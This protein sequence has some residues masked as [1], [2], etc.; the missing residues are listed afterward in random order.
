M[1]NRKARDPSCDYSVERGH[2]GMKRNRG[3]HGPVRDTDPVGSILPGVK[4]LQK[5]GEENVRAAGKMVA[6]P[7]PRKRQPTEG[8]NGVG[9]TKA[10]LKKAKAAR[11]AEVGKV[12]AK[13]ASDMAGQMAAD[14]ERFSQ[15][16]DRAVQE[17]SAMMARQMAGTPGRAQ[18]ILKNKRV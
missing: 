3:Y 5:Q 18:A 16:H 9:P 4:A 13:A 7:T 10:N 2:G 15:E 11:R 8:P 6:K 17:G 12:A 1:A 14:Q